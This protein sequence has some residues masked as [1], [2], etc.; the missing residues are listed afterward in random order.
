[1]DE[2]HDLVIRN[3]EIYDGTGGAPRSGALAIDADRIAAV[4]DVEGPGA[5]EL[6]ASGLAAAPGF[7]DVHTHDDFA[8]VL[9][10]DMAFKIEGGV[11]TCVVGNCGM[12]AAPWAQARMMARAFHPNQ[13]LPEWEGYAGYAARFDAEPA[14]TNI[15]FLVGHG[16]MRA[17]A[18]GGERRAP[19]AGE[20][21]QMQATLE[22]GL[23][24][25]AVG[26]STGLIY[27]P[28]RHASTDEIVALASGM[29]GTRGLYATHMRDEGAGLVESVEEAIAVGER[30]GVPVQISH[31]KASGPENWGLV[32]KSLARIE[33][34]QARGLDVH[35]DQYPYTAG[36]TVLA[37]VASGLKSGLGKITPDAIVVAS[38]KSHPEWE[39]RSLAVLA[40]E[41]GLAWR[42]AADHVLAAEPMATCVMHTMSEDDVRQVM[43]HPST[44]I[45]S[46]G[47]PTLDGKP[48]PRLYGTFARVLGHYARDLGLFSIAEG[49]HRMTGFPARK[50]GLVD[51]GALEPGAFADI[52][53][54]DAEEIIDR[55]TFEDP[56]HAPAGVAHVFVNGEH[57]VRDGAHTGSR[58]GRVLRRAD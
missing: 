24:A 10:P 45:G 14:S 51:R 37:A 16:T 19:D 28:G 6:D 27:E 58:P 38:T 23:A 36:S 32:A 49:V 8:A 2:R 48:H 46:D 42:D 41:L 22:E 43:H 55:G 11:T 15:G 47:I 50:F 5:V 17:A 30:A 56:N 29:R 25:G 4:G 21:A 26:L 13:E 44:M 20:L 12:G 3:V 31:H 40:E 39:G 9:H 53:L 7:I 52:V 54:F 18:M 34:A 35:A 1:M 33:A 57:V